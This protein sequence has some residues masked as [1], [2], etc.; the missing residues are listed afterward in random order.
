ML[1]GSDESDKV[2]KD[3]IRGAFFKKKN[4]SNIL[5]G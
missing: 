2:E 5:I 3:L 4:E 1:I